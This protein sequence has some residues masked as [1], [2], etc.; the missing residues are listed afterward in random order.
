MQENAPSI[1]NKSPRTP[2]SNHGSSLGSAMNDAEVSIP[3]ADNLPPRPVNTP[4]FDAHQA[5]VANKVCYEH[6]NINANKNTQAIEIDEKLFTDHEPTM[7]E[8]EKHKDNFMNFK[9]SIEH[10]FACCSR[11]DIS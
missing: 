10:P 11:D 6:N 5:N 7:N 1:H 9:S 4:L 3:D 2:S 8:A